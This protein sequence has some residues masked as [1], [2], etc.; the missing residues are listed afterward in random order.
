MPSCLGPEG[1]QGETPQPLR[2]CLQERSA[3]ADP[4]LGPMP[5]QASTGIRVTRGPQSS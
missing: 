5:C 2:E 3:G 4:M 1:Q